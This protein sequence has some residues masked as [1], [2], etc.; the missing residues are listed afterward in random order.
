[1]L[2]DWRVRQ[3]GDPDQAFPNSR[4]ASCDGD[5]VPIFLGAQRFIQH[6]RDPN[7]RVPPNVCVP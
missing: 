2:P 1:M 5:E 4:L 7:V 3:A 6:S